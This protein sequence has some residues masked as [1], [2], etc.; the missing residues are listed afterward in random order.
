MSA[1]LPGGP[2]GAAA[3]HL[4]E[5]AQTEPV[6]DIIGARLRNKAAG[7]IPALTT[8]CSVAAEWRCSSAENDFFVLFFFLFIVSIVVCYHQV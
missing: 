7:V 6:P 3:I 1:T 2:S 4:I 5:H 8:K